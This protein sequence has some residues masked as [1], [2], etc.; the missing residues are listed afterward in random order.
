MYSF[1]D[2]ET[3]GN[4]AL[5]HHMTEIA[6]LNYDGV[7]ITDRFITLLRPAL[8]VPYF[9]SQL[10]GITREMVYDAPLFEEVAA[11]IDELTY[12]R[13]LVAH[14]AH[15]DY[16]FL[17]Q[18]F[19]AIGKAFQRRTLCT[20][21]LS[22]KIIPGFP[23]Y[24]LNKL[25]RS[26]SISQYPAHR[27]E[28][29]A[30]AALEVFCHL[31]HADKARMIEASIVKKDAEYNYPPNLPQEIIMSLP[32][33]AG[34]YYFLDQQGKVLYIGK[35]KSLKHRINSHF[36]VNSSTRIRTRLMNSI[37]SIRYELCGNELVAMLMES[38]E[39]K[40]HFP[41]FNIA[42]KF[43]DFNY[44]VYCYED[45]NGYL[46]F[47]IRKLKYQD[48]P[49]LS[50]PA[51]PA[52]RAFLSK[53][54]KEFNLCAKLSGLQ[55]MQGACLHHEAGVCDGACCGKVTSMHYNMRVKNALS[56]FKSESKSF[57]LLGTGR[58]KSE[59]SIVV[60]EDGK[61][62]GFG[63]SEKARTPADF[64]SAKKLINHYTDNSEVQRIIYSFL[65]KNNAYSLLTESSYINNN[66]SDSELK[67]DSYL[68]I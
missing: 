21:R 62:L 53:K 20:L 14:N 28:S 32:V 9:I 23:S 1:L 27:A 5:R 49:L 29:D 16:T 7:A 8:E 59:C 40:K 2:I 48:R 35:A 55:R 25:C 31:Q 34:V 44:G 43:T 45:G 57:A 56:A 10:T 12:G 17:K 64:S 61:Y 13:I 63:F 19:S 47:G 67:D 65:N 6:I 58:K 39:I 36:G 68:L 4:H 50:F 52:A 46:R 66:K 30:L 41:P 54:I 38:A 22:R 11:K 37:Y 60:M 26:L 42:Q 33:A 51:L 24:A 3:T 18:A 15:F